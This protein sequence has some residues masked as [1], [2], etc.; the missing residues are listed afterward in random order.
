V[1]LCGLAWAAG[2]IH[3]RAAIEHLPVSAAEAV[4]F[5]LLAAAQLLLGV[6][7]YR[8]PSRTLLVTAALGSV[9]V[10]VLWVVSRTVGL[11]VGPQ[12][13]VPERVGALDV[14]ASADELVLAVLA[15]IRVRGDAA[16]R[17]G[18]RG[19]RVGVTL[20]A[21]VLLLLSSLSVI[22]TANHTH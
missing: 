3:V 14:L 12:P 4:F 5:E 9:A 19:T 6:M 15:L 16:T 21:L 10:V 22:A 1:L 13:W 7:L 18:W 17:G 2:F 8:R 11:P 20:I